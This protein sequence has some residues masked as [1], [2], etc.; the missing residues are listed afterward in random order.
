MAKSSNMIS[1]LVVILPL[2]CAALSAHAEEID[3][4]R[5]YASCMKEARA[6]PQKG[7]D[8]SV[9][10]LN[11][12]GGDAARHCQA[13]ALIGL[14][15]TS[16]AASKLEELAQDTKSE[17][18]FRAEL[19]A[20]AA[21]AW[22]LAGNA[23]R[24]EAVLTAAIKLDPSDMELRID[25][26]QSLAQRGDFSSAIEDLTTVLAVE[27]GKAEALVFRASAYRQN[28]QTEAAAADLTKVLSQNPGNPEAML[29]R[30]ML[31][32]MQG[33][34]AAARRDWLAVI[35]RAPN[36]ATADT[37]ADNIQLM[38]GNVTGAKRPQAKGK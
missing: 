17:P 29:E 18:R 14:G 19:F 16:E 5:E 7:F 28:G 9:T 38:D 37:A 23:L 8:H 31:E 21:Q 20:Q 32:R 22:M 13:V 6:T 24:A 34:D 36:T 4:R 11:L 30:G 33:D 1:R 27:P 15:S 35:E 25:R 3:Q 10:W 26:S 12:G 2:L